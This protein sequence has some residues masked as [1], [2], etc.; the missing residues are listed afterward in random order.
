M[1]RVNLSDALFDEPEQPRARPR[2]VDDRP[3][4]FTML[5]AARDDER[6]RAVTEDVVARAGIRQTKSMRAD[7]VRALFTL[8][9]RDPEIRARLAGLLR[10]GT[11]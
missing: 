8:A 9:E 3:R 2:P 1:A 7:V 5:N 4:K 11:P 6:A 10:D